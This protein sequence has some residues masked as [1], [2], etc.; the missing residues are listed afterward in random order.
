MVVKDSES[1]HCPP[2]HLKEKLPY[3]WFLNELLRPV[4]QEP[5]R[6]R[7]STVTTLIRSTVGECL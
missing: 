3:T 7:D 2:R 4:V 5:E 1:V 6:H